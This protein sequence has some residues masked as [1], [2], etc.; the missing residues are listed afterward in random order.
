MLFCHFRT[1]CSKSACK[2]AEQFDGT[3]T[4]LPAFL[5]S[6]LYVNRVTFGH[7]NFQTPMNL[8]E[9]IAVRFSIQN[10][11][12]RH[13]VSASFHCPQIVLLTAPVGVQVSGISWRDPTQNFSLLHHRKSLSP[14]R[15]ARNPDKP[16][17]HSGSLHFLPT[18]RVF[19]TICPFRR[20]FGI[21]LLALA[22]VSAIWR[23]GF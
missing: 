18:W 10:G 23:D 5:P 1:N 6:Q 11:Y 14:I 8:A 15:Q 2:C 19:R 21:F 7:T 9:N 20:I 22:A 4:N 12:F 17:F 13:I 16:S 3:E